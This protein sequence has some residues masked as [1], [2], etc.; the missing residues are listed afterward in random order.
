M[1]KNEIG[2]SMVEMLGVLAII[3][4]LSFGALAGYSK[5]ML[6]IRTNKQLEQYNIIVMAI[7]KYYT[8]FAKTS[9]P[10]FLTQYFIELNEVPSNMIKTNVKYQIYDVFNNPIQ[11]QTHSNS[12]IFYIFA[13]ENSKK[14]NLATCLNIFKIAQIYQKDVDGVNIY[15]QRLQK[16][17]INMAKASELCSNKNTGNRYLSIHF[18][19]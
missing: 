13:D 10:S 6:S 17:D 1:K 4:V 19:R 9:E 15:G 7:L 12:T 5:A 2:R 11:I 8:E 14:V 16:T 3:G 18:E